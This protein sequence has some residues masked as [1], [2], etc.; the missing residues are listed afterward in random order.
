MMV[1]PV[2]FPEPRSTM[3]WASRSVL[4]ERIWTDRHKAE[5]PDQSRRSRVPNVTYAFQIFG[6]AVLAY[7]LVA[8]RLLD[9]VI[10]MVITQCAKAWY[11][12]R[13]VLLFEDMKRSRPEYAMWEY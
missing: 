13:I 5:I 3:N 6:L 10:G 12:D 9:V 2:L 11:L 8:L 4:G 1:N 7:G